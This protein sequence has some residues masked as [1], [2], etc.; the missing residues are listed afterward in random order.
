M[1][2][3]I[4]KQ[5]EERIASDLNAI[6]VETKFCE[7]LDECYSFDSVG[8]PFSYM[9]PSSVLQEM[10]PTAFRCGVSDYVDGEDWV[11]VGGDYYETEECIEIREDMVAELEQKIAD[12]EDELD[13]EEEDPDLERLRTSL[14]EL[15]EHSF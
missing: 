3:D 12:L 6:D 8:G 9:T 15:E 4:I 5:L 14:E 1:T 13:E 2:P 7:M 11:E 10:D